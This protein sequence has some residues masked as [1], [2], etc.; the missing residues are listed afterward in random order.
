MAPGAVANSL[1]KQNGDMDRLAA[2]SLSPSVALQVVCLR[3]QYFSPIGS[4]RFP[5]YGHICVSNANLHLSPSRRI[6]RMPMAVFHSQL[7]HSSSPDHSKSTMGRRTLVTD[8]S[9]LRPSRGNKSNMQSNSQSRPSAFRTP[10][11]FPHL[12]GARIP[13]RS[14]LGV[15]IQP[16]PCLLTQTTTY[17][18]RCRKRC[19]CMHG[20]LSFSS[21]N[22]F[23][24]SRKL[25]VH[26][27]IH[28]SF[29]YR[30]YAA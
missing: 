28:K 1:F 20:R 30:T 7:G 27:F 5:V 14:V 15:L 24:E 11:Q 22:I 9:E 6:L 21:H 17:G 12:I 3:F 29:K 4:T 10:P 19:Q 23:L 18:D 2:T 13:P 8:R 26:M 25:M 16:P